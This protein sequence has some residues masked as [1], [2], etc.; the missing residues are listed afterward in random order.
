MEKHIKSK[1]GNCHIFTYNLAEWILNWTEDN[2]LILKNASSG[3]HALFFLDIGL[4]SKMKMAV[5]NPRTPWSSNTG[6]WESW[7]LIEVSPNH[8]HISS[9]GHYLNKTLGRT[10]NI[11]KAATL[12]FYFYRE[13]VLKLEDDLES[14]ANDETEETEL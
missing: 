4:A 3:T 14:D 5:W 9:N 11:E 13:N 2:K 6:N 8:Y 7:T 12:S 1:I 10:K